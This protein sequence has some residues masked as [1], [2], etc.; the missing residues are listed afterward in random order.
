[1]IVRAYLIFVC[2]KPQEDFTER[3]W[4]VNALTC[5]TTV[6]FRINCTSHFW[7]AT[8]Q[9]YTWIKLISYRGTP[10]YSVQCLIVHY[11]YFTV[12]MSWFFEYKH[13]WCDD[14]IGLFMT[15]NWKHFRLSGGYCT[16][17]QYLFLI[18]LLNMTCPMSFIA[19]KLWLDNEICIFSLHTFASLQSIYQNCP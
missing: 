1:M 8:L 11:G 16:F 14:Y 3:N 15:S 4:D 9:D 7:N 17:K 5:K 2:K 13:W 19:F 6:G 18:F 12:R 10:S